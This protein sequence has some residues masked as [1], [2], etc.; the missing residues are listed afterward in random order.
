MKAIETAR[1]GIKVLAYAATFG[2]VTHTPR[3][4]TPAQALPKLLYCTTLHAASA[5]RVLFWF[6]FL[7]FETDIASGVP[8]YAPA[9]TCARTSRP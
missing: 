5:A 3:H 1:D 2:L 6:L 4:P 8:D 9:Q 7:A